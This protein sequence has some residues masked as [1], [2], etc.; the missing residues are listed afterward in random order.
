MNHR[1]ILNSKLMN[2]IKKSN[3]ILL[4]L[5]LCVIAYWIYV[6]IEGYRHRLFVAQHGI[7][8]IAI[9]TQEIPRKSGAN[10]FNFNYDYKGVEYEF[11]DCLNALLSEQINVGD[12]V[13]IMYLTK[14][15][16]YANINEN[17]RYQS[18]YGIP[19]QTG[20]KKL[21]KCATYDDVEYNTE[22]TLFSF[23]ETIKTK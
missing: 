11:H 14:D 18:C 17:Y 21:P 16:K 4:I 2:K 8:D 1:F 9:I 22:N 23:P 7:Y 10:E 6:S 20:W 5:F 15:P 12:T 19:P 3:L 13:I